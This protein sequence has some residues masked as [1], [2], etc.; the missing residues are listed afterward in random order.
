VF[1]V[2]PGYG[3]FTLPAETLVRWGFGAG[4]EQNF[5]TPAEFFDAGRRDRLDPRR[6]RIQGGRAK[7]CFAKAC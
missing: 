7:S 6:S 4:A 5:E 2:S 3:E 1:G